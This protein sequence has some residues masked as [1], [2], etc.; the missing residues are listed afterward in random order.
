MKTEYGNSFEEINKHREE[1]TKAITHYK[2]F[3]QHTKQ[4]IFSHSNTQNFSIS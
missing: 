3:L 4:F 1:R 2:I